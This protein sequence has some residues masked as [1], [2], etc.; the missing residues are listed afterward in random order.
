MIKRIIL[1][2]ML[3]VVAAIIGW[4]GLSVYS[5]ACGQQNMNQGQSGVPDK[6]EATYSLRIENTKGLVMTSDCEVYGDKVG[7]R[8]FVLEGFWEMRGQKFI[9]KDAE[10]ILDEAIFGEITLKRR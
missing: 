7:S 4:L 10:L 1:V 3:I 6:E 5:C 2:M 8:V 9:Y